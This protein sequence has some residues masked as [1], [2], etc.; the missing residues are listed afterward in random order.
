MYTDIACIHGQAGES[1]YTVKGACV[2]C[3]M[4]V[5]TFVAASIKLRFRGVGLIFCLVLLSTVFQRL[6]RTSQN[7]S[8]PYILPYKLFSALSDSRENDRDIFEFIVG[9]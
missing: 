8:V 6:L 5:G 7:L 3:R 9:T 2:P 1:G 4:C